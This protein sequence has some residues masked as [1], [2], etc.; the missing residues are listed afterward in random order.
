MLGSAAFQGRAAFP[1]AI[2]KTNGISILSA[3]EL[4]IHEDE[5]RLQGTIRVQLKCELEGKIL[6]ILRLE[7]A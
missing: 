4:R 1:K 5:M 6:H 7:C 3:L 2:T